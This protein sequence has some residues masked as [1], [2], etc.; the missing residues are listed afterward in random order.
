MMP[1]PTVSKRTK[2]TRHK[3]R[4]TQSSFRRSTTPSANEEIQQLRD[5]IMH[6]RS[7]VTEQEESIAFLR[8]L[9]SQRWFD[10]E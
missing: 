4:G 5:Q 10:A 7:T 1:T 6:L 8:D 3:A 9:L 2:S